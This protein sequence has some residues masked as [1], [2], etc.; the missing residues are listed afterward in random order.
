M[1]PVVC[2]W[3]GMC[4][5]LVCT[6]CVCLW[7][8]CIVCVVYVCV[9]VGGGGGRCSAGSQDPEVRVFVLKVSLH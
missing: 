4:V 5:F 8:K 2:V 3:C 1:C 9:C 7:C 6:V